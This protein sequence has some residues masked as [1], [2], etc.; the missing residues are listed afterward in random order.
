MKQLFTFLTLILLGFGLNAQYIYNDYDANQNVVFMAWPNMPTPMANPH[1]T[2]INTSANVAEFI[3][4]DWAQWDNI[5]T[6]VLP[7]TIDFTTGTVFSIKVYSPI[8]CDV[9]FKLEGNAAPVERL[10]SITTPNQ[11]VQLDFD[12]TGEATDVFNKLVIF[13]DFATFNANTFYFDD[14]QGPEYNTGGGGGG[15]L[16]L[17]V[18]FDDQT[19]AYDLTDFGGNFSEIIVDPDDASNNIVKTIKQAT[20]ELWAGTTVGGSVGFADPIPF[21]TDETIMGVVV[22]SPEVGVPV[23][24]KVEDANN[25][26]IT[27]ETEAITTIAMAWD[28]LF[29]NFANPVTGTPALNPANN[30]NL[31]SIF[32]NFGTTGA[33]AGEQTYYWDY[34][35]F[36]GAPDPKPLLSLNIQDNFENDGWGT[37][38][39]WFFQDPDM[40]PMLTTTDPVNG[41][42][43]VADYNRTGA[44]PYTNAQFILE[45]RIDL[46]ERNKF[47]LDVYFPSTNDYSGALTTTAAIKL[48]NSLLGGNAWTTQTEILITVTEMDQWVTL[49]FDFSGVADREDYDQVVVQLGGEGHNVPGQ[50]YFDNLY[51]K[52]VP[53][54]TILSPNGGEMIN[55]GSQFDIEW[56]YDYWTG[57]V[58]IELIKGDGTPQ[59]VG[60][61]VNVADTLLTW[62]VFAT[63]EPGSDYRIIITSTDNSFPTD[64]SDVYFTIVNANELNAN[65]LA[66]TNTIISGDS[67]MYTD[68]STGAVVSWLWTFEGG[69]PATF[70]G[71]QPPYIQYL[72]GGMYDVTLEVNDGITTSTLTMEDYIMVGTL[73]VADFMADQ[74]SILSGQ[75]IDFTNLST[76]DDLTYSWYFEGGTPEMSSDEMPTGIVYNEVGLFDVELIVTNEFGADTMLMVEYIEVRP[77]GIDQNPEAGMAIYPNPAQNNLTIQMDNSSNYSIQLLRMDGQM[78]IEQHASD[79]I[80]QLDVSK[81]SSGIYIIQVKSLST[82]EIFTKK[83]LIQ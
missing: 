39:E 32:F 9:L 34:M 74:T 17:P 60:M 50:F 8:V 45:H 30:Y 1:S 49:L 18:T 71:Q 59:L 10:Q 77:V 31:A 4:T 27:C 81:L 21:T 54:V 37:I 44:F 78:V 40:N 13:L 20:A 25:S 19:A 48:Q 67:I 80:S 36:K 76:G 63:Q 61:N 2:G 65:F 26:G 73:P 43:T 83:I 69:T 52:H 28:T 11:W 5:Y 24:L 29:F 7:G 41:S 62:S 64:T 68:L 72:T 70:E 79:K 3:R 58:D 51:L 23:R 15:T 57:S 22:W 66:D 35:Y 82:P 46:T 42:N 55:Q 14:I 75:S 16:T 6:D 53:Y 12:F 33:V 56:D 47:E 38:N